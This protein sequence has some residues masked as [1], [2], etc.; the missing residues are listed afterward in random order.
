MANSSAAS[1]RLDRV[2]IC[3]GHLIA[4]SSLLTDNDNETAGGYLS[5]FY[6]V[7]RAMRMDEIEALGG[8]HAAG[9]NVPGAPATPLPHRMLRK[10]GAIG[11]RGGF[12]CW[13]ADNTMASVRYCPEQQRAGD[14]ID[15]VFPRRAS[16]CLFTD[17][18]I[19]RTT[20][21]TGAV[22]SMTVAQT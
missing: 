11:H 14:E 19:D 20:D 17:S 8:P 18:T 16:V 1:V 6:F 21:G 3:A 7:D 10:V 22:A 5:S 15:T 13:H 2:L 9:A 12:F 4:L